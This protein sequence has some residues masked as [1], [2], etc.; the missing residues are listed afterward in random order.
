M[1]V[2]YSIIPASFLEDEEEEEPAGVLTQRSDLFHNVDCRGPCSAILL[3]CM[4]VSLL[5]E[6]GISSWGSFAIPVDGFG[7]TICR[8]VY[9]L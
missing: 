9:G 3:L 8:R 2:T 4:H 6:N 7:P 1:E 5:C